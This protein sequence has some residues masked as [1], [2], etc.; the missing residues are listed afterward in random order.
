MAISNFKRYEKK[1]IVN[2]EQ[3]SIIFPHLSEHMNYDAFCLNGQEYGVY[4]IYYDTPDDYLIR[5]SLEKPYY[6]EKLRMRSYDSPVAADSTV[7]L[8]I[9]KK[10]GGIV[11]KRR[12]ILEYRQAMDFIEKGIRP[13]FS[14]GEYINNQVMNELEVFL[15]NYDVSPK[16]Y[17][18]YQRF[19]F[20]GKEDKNFRMTFDRE[21]TTRRKDLSL[22]LPSYGTVLLPPEIFLMEIKINGSLPLWLA[23]LLSELGIFKTSFSKYGRAYKKYAADEPEGTLVCAAEAAGIYAF[24][25]K[26]ADSSALC[27]QIQTANGAWIS[28]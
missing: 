22:A 2:A 12:V 10:I 7:F 17:I 14:E 9:K 26:S 5:E 23:H 21:I 28:C 3:L 4:N 6:K 20:F 16:Q 27:T 18:S 15:K 19:A 1:F 13:Q 8:E 24:S 11:T 25:S